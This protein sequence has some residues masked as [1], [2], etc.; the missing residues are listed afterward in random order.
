MSFTRFYDDE[1]RIKKRLQESTGPSRYILNVPGNGNTPNYFED[2][3]IRL[4][5][6]G[7]NL[8]D[9]KHDVEGYL[10]GYN[11]ANYN[12]CQFCS[13]ENIQNQHT[14]DR[15]KYPTQ[16][17]TTE[18]TR[19]TQPSWELKGIENNRWNILY[20]NPQDIIYEPLQNITSSRITQK[21]NFKPKYPNI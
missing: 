7:A 21:E 14:Y 4:Q 20:Y 9:N 19:T 12:D 17:T 6:W 1:S 3:H 15:D 11:K 10:K 16:P 8:Y 18:E 2:T 5:K 13:N